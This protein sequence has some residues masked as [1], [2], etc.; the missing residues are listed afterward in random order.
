MS[1]DLCPICGYHESINVQLNAHVMNTFINQFKGKAVFNK[2]NDVLTFTTIDTKTGQE[3][4]WTKVGL[5]DDQNI[6]KLDE[7]KVLKQP[8]AEPAKG[9]VPIK[10][11]VF[12]TDDSLIAPPLANTPIATATGVQPASPTVTVFGGAPITPQP[13]FVLKS[14]PSTPITP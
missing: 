6:V 7:V 13:K 14:T 12:E 11:I 1:F 5:T 2:G 3:I 4:V 9:T 10:E 8:V